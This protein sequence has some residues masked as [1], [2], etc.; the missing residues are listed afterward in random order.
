MRRL[1]DEERVALWE[2]GPPG[3]GPV[4]D[5]TFAELAALGWG[6]WGRDEEGTVWVVTPAGRLALELDDA[7]RSGLTPPVNPRSSKFTSD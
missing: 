1:T 4:S 5:A 2:F 6:Y 7:A 3:E